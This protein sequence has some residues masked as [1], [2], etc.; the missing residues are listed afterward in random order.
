MPS[1]LP[2]RYGANPQQTPAYAYHPRH[3][4][5]SPKFSRGVAL[6]VGNYMTTWISGTA[7]IVGSESKHQGD[8]EKQTE[9]TIDNIE[10]L[11]S[12]ENFTFHGVPGAGATLHDL[13][14]IRIYLKRR[15]DF[16]IARSICERRFGHV[17]AIYAVA[18]IC[19]PELLIEI[20][21]VAFSRHFPPAAPARNGHDRKL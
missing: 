5:L 12:P 19:R 3:S 2:L 13:A 9:Q 7:S 10:R 16:N 18:D 8:I 15:E 17:P 20:E 14:K 21:G 4:P 11:I 6:V 1:S